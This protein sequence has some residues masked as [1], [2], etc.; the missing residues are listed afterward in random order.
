MATTSITGKQYPSVNEMVGIFGGINKQRLA[1]EDLDRQRKRDKMYGDYLVNQTKLAEQRAELLRTQQ[2]SL[3][4]Y[5]QGQAMRDEA[6]VK[7]ELER[8]QQALA[9]DAINLINKDAEMTYE[10][11]PPGESETKDEFY[12][13]YGSARQALKLKGFEPETITAILERMQPQSKPEERVSISHKL[14]FAGQYPKTITGDLKG[15]IEKVLGITITDD[16]FDDFKSLPTEHQKLVGQYLDRYE[17][18]KIDSEDIPKIFELASEGNILE[19]TTKYP[20]PPK[21]MSRTLHTTGIAT[22]GGPEGIFEK[23]VDSLDAATLWAMY[24]TQ[25][26]PEGI[27]YKPVRK[28]RSQNIPILGRLTENYTIVEDIPSGLETLWPTLDV[29]GKG[30]ARRLLD[31]GVE[32]KD[33]IKRI[34]NAKQISK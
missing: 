17:E 20:L 34:E 11:L 31:A 26:T 9:D 21:D 23:G 19:L 30:L 10:N 25:E 7:L 5:R 3:N 13:R 2:E 27:R 18:G 28:D 22:A 1:Q 15:D 8:H 33:I 16:M 29:E 32:P 12:Q 4:A 24:F 14:Q 6:R